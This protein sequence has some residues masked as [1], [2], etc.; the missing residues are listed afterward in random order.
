[1]Q[2]DRVTFASD[3]SGRTAR[4]WARALLFLLAGLAVAHF[5]VTLYLLADLGSD[6]FT[7]FVQG[8]ARTFGVSVGTMHVILQ[9][10]LIGVMFFT[11]K[12]YIKIGTVVCALFGGPIIDGFTLLLRGAVNGGSPLPLRCASMAVGCTILALGMTFV[13]SSDAG[14][15]ANDLVA[16]VLSD[17]LRRPFRWVRLGC[18]AVFLGLG[19]MLGGQVGAGSVAAVLL[20]G[21]L[22]QFFLPFSRRVAAKF[23]PPAPP[24][25]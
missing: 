11:T 13:I 10:V 19:F 2:N 1:M 24:S 15:G 22:A 12:G 23:L 18:D 25:A 9:V 3:T 20:T 5:G 6:P 7:T 4:D 16:L 8:L 14:T 21:P 17:S